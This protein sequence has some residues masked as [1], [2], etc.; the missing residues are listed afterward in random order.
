[1]S[2]DL[3]A[4][5]TYKMDGLQAMAY[6]I[7]LMW[8]ELC[9][10]EFPDYRHGYGS[11]LP[12][13]D[14]RKSYLFKICL[15]LVYETQGMVEPKDYRL[16]IVAQL[17]TLKSIRNEQGIHALIEPGCLVGDK[18][19]KRWIGWKIDF[20]RR[21]DG[22]LSENLMRVNAVSPNLIILEL[23]RTKKFFT[24]DFPIKANQDIIESCVRERLIRKWLSYKKIS[25]YWA[26]M[27]PWM[28]HS[29][30]KYPPA[31]ALGLDLGV[32]SPACTE[33]IIKRFREIFDYE[34][35]SSDSI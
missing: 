18:A 25:P 26:V 13:G 20:E 29:L 16:Y 27:S 6:K 24:E 14:P 3:E 31:D 11:S 1:M 33:D 9:R 17:Q 23:G 15:K 32:Y 19:W 28:R 2:E 30:K 35:T 7:A 21:K 4:I 5:F 8:Q 22:R 34:F 12:K 10:K